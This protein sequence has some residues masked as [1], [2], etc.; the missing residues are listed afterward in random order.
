MKVLSTK[1]LDDNIINAALDKGI[2][3][4][5]LDFI[6]ARNIDFDL[7]ALGTLIYDA[8]VFTSSNAVAGFFKKE[9][10]H[11]AHLSKPIYSLSGKT[12][13]ALMQ[14]GLHPIATAD[15]AEALA[16]IITGNENIRSVLHICGN[17]A[18]DTL[19]IRLMMGGLCYAP[20][21]V[22]ETIFAGQALDEA[23]DIVMFYSPSGVESFIQKNALDPYILYC[24]IGETTAA[25]LKDV[26][27]G[28]DIILPRQPTPQGML[29]AIIDFKKSIEDT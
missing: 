6:G 11:A 16:G 15:N 12:K 7:S 13:D 5:C 1:L 10:I 28:I 23:Y 19:E 29:K 9:N 14:H 27:E 21:V 18:L 25:R 3:L 22:Y 8:L 20:L 2:T 4:T 26:N 24:C 17:L